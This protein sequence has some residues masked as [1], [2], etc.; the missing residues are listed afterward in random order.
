MPLA[1]KLI[2]CYTEF[3]P[4]GANTVHRP[5]S[6]SQLEELLASPVP[7][8]NARWVSF[9]GSVTTSVKRMLRTHLKLLPSL[10]VTPDAEMHFGGGSVVVPADTALDIPQQFCLSFGA[11]LV[12][13]M[14]ET[15]NEVDCRRAAAA[16]PPYE[17]AAAAAP[18]AGQP[19]LSCRLSAKPRAPT[20]AAS[21]HAAAVSSHAAASSPA[22]AASSPA[23]VASSPV[24]TSSHAAAASSPAAAVS[25]LIRSC[26]RLLVQHGR[27]EAR[28]PFDPREQ[29]FNLFLEPWL[30]GRGCVPSPNEATF[31]EERIPLRSARR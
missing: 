1:P 8:A 23:A 28:V 18:S 29:N 3:S 12:H 26:C 7:Q 11:P 15:A 4:N 19:S 31:S 16:V 10:L 24:A 30:R 14:G 21:S 25:D 5:A 9:T 20:A 17:A 6:T 2:G 13:G 22:A 27:R